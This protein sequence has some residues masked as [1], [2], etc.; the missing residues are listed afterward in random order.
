MM[1]IFSTTKF[2]PREFGYKPRF[3]DPDKEELERR[4]KSRKL[5]NDKGDLTKS[6]LRKEFSGY[7]SA[8]AKH[9]KNNSFLTSSSF[10]LILI[11]VFLMIASYF[12]L[13]NLLPQFMEYLYPGENEGYELLE[14]YDEF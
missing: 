11:V 4:I 10:R 12:V 3:Y 5:T 8:D 9:S 7:R 13:D 14:E 1:K 2:K 6:R